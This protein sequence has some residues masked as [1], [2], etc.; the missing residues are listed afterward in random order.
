MV[1]YKVIYPFADLQDNK[2]VYQP[3]DDFP[4]NDKRRVSKARI[5]ELSGSDNK[6]GR[7]L[8]ESLNVEKSEAEVEE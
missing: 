2:H 4:R 5:E 6:I 3:G 7:P 1:K 8:I